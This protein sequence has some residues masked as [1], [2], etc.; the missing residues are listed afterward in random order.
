MGLSPSETARTATPGPQHVDGRGEAVLMMTDVYRGLEGVE[1]GEIKYLRVLEQVARPWAARRFWPEDEGL[2]QHAIIS[3]HAHI[4][5][6]I[7]H[8]VVPVAEDGSACFT[9]PAEKNLFF[10]ALDQDFMEVQRMRSFLNLRPGETRSCIGC[11]EE[12]RLAPPSGTPMALAHPPSRLGPQPGET[13]PRPIYYPTD[14]QPVLDKH[15]VAC[16]NPKKPEGE[17]DLSGEPTTFFNRSYEQVMSKKLVA[18]IQEFHGP[19][20]RAQKTNVV[21]LPPRSLGSHAS[22]LIAVVREGHYDAK[23]SAEE[24]ARLVT[25]ADANA[26]YYGSYFGRR[27]LKYKD[28]PDFRP[29]PTLESASGTPPPDAQPYAQSPRPP[30]PLVPRLRLGTP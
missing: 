16:H 8:G 10:E 18:Y 21:P 19:Q 4:F 26:P 5:V 22:G 17:L 28:H 25:W 20:P 2:G 12:R 27:N 29:T 1:R 13:V 11:H 3:M 30:A 23:L 24:M 15:C 14:V 6:K 9:V 7:H